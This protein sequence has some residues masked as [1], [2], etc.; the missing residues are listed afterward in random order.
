[1]DSTGVV[2][3]LGFGNGVVRIVALS[4]NTKVGGSVNLLQVWKPHCLAITKMSINDRETVL[5]TGSED[6]TIFLH[7]VSKQKPFVIFNPIGFVDVPSAATAFTWKPN[8]VI[9][10]IY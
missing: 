2:L 3:I 5:V 10:F 4:L 6:N 1:M 7:Q 8:L 9:K